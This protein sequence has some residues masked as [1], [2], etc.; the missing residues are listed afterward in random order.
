MEIGRILWLIHIRRTI[1]HQLLGHE[2]VVQS[3]RGEC[4]LG[5]ESESHEVVFSD[6]SPHRDFDNE[7]QLLFVCQVLL[8]N[9][10]KVL[11]S[12]ERRWTNEL[13][14]VLHADDYPHDVPAANGC[15]VA[16]AVPSVK[17]KPI[18]VHATCSIPKSKLITAASPVTTPIIGTSY[19]LN[20]RE[21]IKM[22]YAI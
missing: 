16:N 17:L 21:R 13:Q 7:L 4:W 22:I 18:A 6:I 11:I 10:T 8:E 19:V 5:E 15:S 12:L 14:H 1:P 9:G 3:L 2:Q 20:L